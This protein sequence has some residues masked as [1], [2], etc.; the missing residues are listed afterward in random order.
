MIDS[1]TEEMPP[2]DLSE[3][4]E[5]LTFLYNSGL[6]GSY[7]SYSAF[8]KQGLERNVVELED[9]VNDIYT[10]FKPHMEFYLTKHFKMI[11]TSSYVRHQIMPWMWKFFMIPYNYITVKRS[12]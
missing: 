4:E 10:S 6:I 9:A 11:K 2:A 7:R 8:E 1:S 12:Q 3:K 5:I